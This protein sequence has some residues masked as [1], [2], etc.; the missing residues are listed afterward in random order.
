MFYSMLED[1]NV[2]DLSLHGAAPVQGA[3]AEKY[4]ANVW[5][6]DPKRL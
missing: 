6:W 4:L 3:Q 1:G 2:D 5:I